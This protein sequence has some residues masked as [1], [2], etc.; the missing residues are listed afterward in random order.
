[1]K[2]VLGGWTSLTM[3]ARSSLAYYTLRQVPAVAGSPFPDLLCQVGMAKKDFRGKP[4]LT[5][6]EARQRQNVDHVEK[7][8]GADSRD[9]G[10]SF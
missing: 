8:N 7:V 9:A 10:Q 4:Q 6:L 2:A 3:H 1:M 5:L